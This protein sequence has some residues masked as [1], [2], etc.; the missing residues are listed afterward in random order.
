MIP[1]E[2]PPQLGG[3]SGLSIAARWFLDRGYTVSI[4]L[5]PAAYDLITESDEG[6]KRIQVK[7]TRQQDRIPVCRNVRDPNARRNANGTRKK[8]PY[9]ADEVDYFFIVTPDAMFL[10][11]FEFVAGRIGIALNEKLKEFVIY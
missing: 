1:F 7:V 5:E 8:V 11:P 6:L 4:P 3:Q 9:K 10:I 2:K